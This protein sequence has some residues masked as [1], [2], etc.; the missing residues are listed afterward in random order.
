MDIQNDKNIVVAGK[1]VSA[2]TINT[3][4]VKH[5]PASRLS[6]E[7]VAPLQLTAEEVARISSNH[8]QVR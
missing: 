4:E 2:A 7:D 5:Y 1:V 8:S 6:L 3:D